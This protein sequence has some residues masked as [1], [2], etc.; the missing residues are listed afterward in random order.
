MDQFRLRILLIVLPSSASG[1]RSP[2]LGFISRCEVDATLHV[3]TSV[4][5]RQTYSTRTE[6]AKCAKGIFVHQN[7]PGHFPSSICSTISLPVLRFSTSFSLRYC[8]KLLCTLC[9]YLFSL[10]C[11]LLKKCPHFDRRM[12]IL[13]LKMYSNSDNNTYTHTQLQLLTARCQ[14][15]VTTRRVHATIQRLGLADTGQVPGFCVKAAR[16]WV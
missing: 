9:I 6:R 13:V 12:C 15:T 16:F 14:V 1:V 4:R 11:E 10:I 5:L 2:F 8:N 3:V 7:G